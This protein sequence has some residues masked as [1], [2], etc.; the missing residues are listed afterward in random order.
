MSPRLAALLYAT[1]RHF[2]DRPITVIAGY[3]A[4]KVARKKGN[5]KSP[6]KKGIA[7]DFRIDGVDNTVLRD[8]LRDT[9]TG[10][11]V[12][13]YPNAGFIHLDA[14]GGK[15]AFWIDYSGPGE[16]AEYSR[17]PD[18][19]LV[20]GRVVERTRGQGG[21]PRDFEILGDDDGDGVLSFAD[22]PGTLD[23]IP[24]LAAPAPLPRLPAIPATATVSADPN[25][26]VGRA[27]GSETPPE[28]R[29]ETPNAI[30]HPAVAPGSP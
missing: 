29:N 12:G 7:C 16:R 4:P 11:G 2:D 17:D 21:Q 25:P 10:V 15:S 26:A 22:D 13:Y 3:R 8:Y 19:D 30:A 20:S 23:L 28:T 6:H 27:A 5:P 14:R 9:Y 18:G 1:A 24:I